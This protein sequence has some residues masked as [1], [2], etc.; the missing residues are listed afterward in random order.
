MK[1]K[2]KTISILFVAILTLGI[3]VN[4]VNASTYP[5]VISQSPY[6]AKAG[7][8]VIV[9]ATVDMGLSIDVIEDAKLTY[10]IN[11]VSQI[12]IEC[13]EELPTHKSFV[14][15]TF[16]AFA[17][18]DLVRYSI[19]LDYECESSYTSEWYEIDLT[20]GEQTTDTTTDTN[21]TNGIGLSI[22]YLIISFIVISSIVL[23]NKRRNLVKVKNS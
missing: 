12:D 6:P 10:S 8:V 20:E 21:G 17:K 14:T 13:N 23:I 2:L 9:T 15:F 18:G 16:G 3:Y 22:N 4:C 19:F 7:D 1:M 5:V 11:T